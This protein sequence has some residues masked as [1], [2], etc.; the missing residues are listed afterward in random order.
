MR[1][2]DFPCCGHE[3]G[4]CPDF[5]ESGRQIDMKCVCGASVPLTSRSSLCGPCLSAPDPDGDGYD[6]YGY[7]D[8]DGYGYDGYEEEEE[9]SEEEEACLMDSPDHY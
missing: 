1:C 7:D 4:C 6:D 8:Y 9:D 2:E 3:L 5:D